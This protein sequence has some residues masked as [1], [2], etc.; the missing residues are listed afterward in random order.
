MLGCSGWL[1]CFFFVVVRALVV[2]ALLNKSQDTERS[3]RG[4]SRPRENAGIAYGVRLC[5]LGYKC[6]GADFGSGDV[7]TTGPGAPLLMAQPDVSCRKSALLSHLP[8]WLHCRGLCTAA[9]NSKE[10]D[11]GDQAYL[12]SVQVSFYLWTPEAASPA[13][14]PLRAALCEGCSDPTRTCSQT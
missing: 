14:L 4:W 12:A 13:C 6:H 1:L 11:G 7:H 9:L 8:F 10:A 2:R 3:A 5:P